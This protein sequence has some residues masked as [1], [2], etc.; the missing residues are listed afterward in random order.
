[1]SSKLRVVRE[2]AYAEEKQ[3]MQH[4]AVWAN[5]LSGRGSSEP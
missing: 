1:M 2:W 5:C 4:Y 3:P